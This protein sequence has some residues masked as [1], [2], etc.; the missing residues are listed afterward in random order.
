LDIYQSIIV[1]SFGGQKTKEARMKRFFIPIVVFI[2][3]SLTLSNVFAEERVEPG[4]VAEKGGILIGKGRLVF[5]PGFQYTHISTQRLDIT[6]FTV[7]PALVIGIIHIEEIKRDILVPSV[8]FKY[9]ITDWAQL[10]IKVPYLVRFD[11][12]AFGTAPDRISRDVNESGIGDV[13]G[14][15][16]LHLIREKG[17]RPD[18]IASVKVKSR[19]GKAPYGL[20]TETVR[21]YTIPKELPLGSGHWA[22]EPGFTF[23]KTAEPAV[24]FAN[25]SYFYHIKRDVG[26]GIGTVDPSDSINYGLGVAYA[27]SEKVAL[28]TTFEQKFFN[29]TKINGV[30]QAGTDIT[31]ASLLF[32]A[33]YAY[34]PK[35][36]LSLTIGIGLTPDSPDVQVNLRMPISLL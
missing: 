25:I 2:V 23:M 26:H 32:G 28:S 14:A 30:K 15:I 29:K 16:L 21:G 18:V 3:L 20:E 8:T 9:G 31:T 33:S 35:R 11:R 1:K 17:A 4:I 22:V 13:E 7:L 19:T 27:L 5:E 34:D 24:L 36:S 10:D 12:Y 6:G